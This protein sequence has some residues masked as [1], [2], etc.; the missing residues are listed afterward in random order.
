[1]KINNPLCHIR[2]LHATTQKRINDTEMSN[3]LKVMLMYALSNWSRIILNKILHQ[4]GVAWRRSG[5]DTAEV[6]WKP[7]IA[8]IAALNSSVWLGLVAL[9]FFLTIQHR[10]SEGLRSG[11]LA[12]QLSPVIPW[13]VHQLLVVLALWA[14]AKCFWLKE[15]TISINQPTEAWSAL[16]YLN[17]WQWWSMQWWHWTS[18]NTVDQ[19]QQYNSMVV[20]HH[21][22]LSEFWVKEAIYPAI[23]EHLVPP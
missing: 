17:W 18:E 4:W 13:S 5:C 6:L 2:I 22:V 3:F 21:C 12:G 8:L 15:M 23:L 11:H 14:G 9:I 10:F 20:L 1:M 7:R 16:K 19:H